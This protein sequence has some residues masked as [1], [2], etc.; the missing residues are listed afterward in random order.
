[1]SNQCTNC[2]HGLVAIKRRWVPEWL[3]AMFKWVIVYQPFRWIFTTPVMPVSEKEVKLE[4]LHEN[5]C[6]NCKYIATVIGPD[7]SLVDIYWCPQNG[8][9]TWIAR[10]GDEAEYTTLPENMVS[11]AQD[12]VNPWWDLL[13]QFARVHQKK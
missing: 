7:D 4:P 2:E 11:T 13:L 1:M 9:P 10:Y 5:D 3:F 8:Q 6:P 12:G